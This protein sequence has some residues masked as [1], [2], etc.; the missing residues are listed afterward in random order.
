MPRARTVCRTPGCPTLTPTGLCPEHT[1][2]ADQT[3]GT[4]HDRGY[5]ATHTRLRGEWAP[6]VAA[7]TVA[8]ARC[9]KPI[10]PGS[11]WDLGHNDERTAWTGPEHRYCNR[12]AG[13]RASQYR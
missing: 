11:P 3:R 2:A 6:Q 10:P 7:G 8:C 4:R 5:D 12:S 9:R 1:R 13:Q